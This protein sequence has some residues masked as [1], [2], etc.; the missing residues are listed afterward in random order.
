MDKRKAYP[1]IKASDF[2]KSHQDLIKSFV[3]KSDRSEIEKL[4]EQ[5]NRTLKKIVKQR[6]IT[7]TDVLKND[8]RFTNTNGG[9]FGIADEL[10]SQDGLGKIKVISNDEFE[11]VIVSRGRNQD[12]SELNAL[13]HNSKIKKGY[14]HYVNEDNPFVQT[15]IRQKYDMDKY[16]QDLSKVKR[17]QSYIEKKGFDIVPQDK[18]FGTIKES[19]FVTNFGKLQ[20]KKSQSIVQAGLKSNNPF[21]RNMRRESRPL[22]EGMGH[23]WFGRM[24]K[25]STAFGSPFRLGEFSDILKLSS[26]TIDK[27]FNNQYGIDTETTSLKASRDSIVQIS[28]KQG[29]KYKSLFMQNKNFNLKDHDFLMKT[30]IGAINTNSPIDFSKEA[31]LPSY[32]KN[33]KTLQGSFDGQVEARVLR[34]LAAQEEVK[35]YLKQAKSEK[36]NILMMNANFEINQFNEFFDGQSPVNFSDDY[37]KFRRKSNNKANSIYEKLRR[38]EISETDAFDSLVNIQKEKSTF[39]INEALSRKGKIIEIQELAKTLSAVAQQKGLI[40]KTGSF[41]VASNMEF[42]AQTLLGEKEWHEAN[43]DNSQQGRVASRLVETIQDIESGKLN[44][45]TTQNWLQARNAQVENLH[46]TSM[47]KSIKSEYAQTGDY[48]KLNPQYN[49]ERVLLSNSPIDSQALYSKAVS[50]FTQSQEYK[51]S[52]NSN[53]SIQS[54]RATDTLKKVRV[55]SML[56]GGLLLGS[57]LTNIFKFSGSDDDANTIEGLRHEGVAGSQRQINTSFGSGFRNEKF[58]GS[59]NEDPEEGMWGNL[60]A[61][62]L[63]ATAYQVFKHQALNRRLN[64]VTYLGALAPNMDNEKLLNRSNA[65][66]QDVIVAGVR[67]MEAG[68]GGFPRA[69]GI[70][71]LLSQG[72]YDTADFTVDLTTSS[73]ETYA[74]YMDKILNRK[75][76]TEGVTSL[77]FKGGRLSLNK[78]G[79]LEE[80]TGQFSLMKTVTDYNQTKKISGLA[81][82]QLYTNGIKN[83]D[84]MAEQPFLI[85]GGKGPWKKHRD[86]FNAFAHES[87]SKPLKLL[88]DPLEGLRDIIPGIDDHLPSWVKRTLGPKG[89]TRF[90]NIGLDGQELVDTVP[91]MLK[92]HAGKMA[93]FGAAVY[94]GLGTLNYGAQAIGPDGTPIGDAGLIGAAAYGVRAVHETYARISD[95]TGLTAMRDYIESK[96][97][98]SDGFQST[99]GLTLAGGLFGAAY[100]SLQDVALESTST[101]K[102]E[103]FLESNKKS[104]MDGPLGK[105]FKGEMTNVSKK[106]KTGGA[107]GFA[108]ALPFTLAGLGTDKSA[109]E[110]RQEYSGEK[111]VAIRKGRFWESGFTPFEGGEIDYYAKNWYAK[112]MDNAKDKELYG[113]DMSPIGSAVRGLVDPYWLEKKRYH[114]QPYPVTGPDGSMMGIFGPAY[115]ATLGR[116]L[117][118]V[119]TMHEGALPPELLNNTEYDADALLRKQWNSTLEFMGLRGFTLGAVKENLTGSKEIFADPNEARSAKDIDSVVRDFYD[120]QLGGGLLTTEALRRVFQSSD[121]FQKAQMGSSINLNPLQNRMP[122]WMPGAEYIK[123]FKSGD[124][125]NKV[126]DGYSRLPGAGFA[127]QYEDLEGVKPE[128][129]ADIYKYKILADVAYGSSQFREV[130]GRLQNRELTEYEQDIFEQVQIQIDEKRDSKVNVRD[131]STYDSFLGRYSAMVTDLARSNPLETLLP[132]SPA[133][134]FLGPP[135]LEDY[136]AEQQYSKE[137]RNW[138]NPIDDFLLPAVS[139]T[140]NNLGMGGINMNDQAEAENYFDKVDYTKYSNLAREAQASG[141]LKLADQY[142]I[143]AQKTYS[144]KDLYSHSANVSSA[145]PQSERKMYNYFVESDFNTKE[146]M[147]PN[148]NPR[149]RDAYQ[150]QYDK[151]LQADALRNRHG[152]DQRRV[153]R[154]IQ[155]RQQAI[156]N[157][158]NAEM[159][160]F[161]SNM[162]KSN[163]SGWDPGV[164]NS[165]VK[166]KYINNRASDY[167]YQRSPRDNPQETSA[168]SQVN[169][170]L[171]NKVS[172]DSHYSDLNKAG[173]EN[174]LVVIRPGLDN[175]AD[176]NITV[177]RRDEQNGLL[178]EWGYIV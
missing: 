51:L 133:H 93:G 75:I 80:V 20:D 154:E 143:M 172:Y 69:F 84:A 57:S 3:Q 178:R 104:K 12:K 4:Q 161:K 64:D 13:M 149:Y 130:K 144:A 142:T 165:R 36:K 33:L 125:F 39:I 100:G 10:S 155:K 150:A 141:D 54:A 113:G 114:D 128:D 25:L 42:L 86:F 15:T 106:A 2:G 68:L 171:S 151:A 91:G 17:V 158:R 43:L 174:A 166:N 89:P 112:L 109:E 98:G 132:F 159:Q 127:S 102:Y 99:I 164:N 70:G 140:M 61:T 88:A 6:R 71:D 97:P 62:G 85:T 7:E 169:I 77:H 177:D 92:K 168:A 148:V 105:I 50:E 129:Y 116:I 37:I 103:T 34:R 48:Q 90:I 107:I 111:D 153:L 28:L 146:K 67:R 152:S 9:D 11:R 175:N 22:I 167:H 41:A 35:S 101:S 176:L 78:N 65:R 83:L 47:L 119:A 138:A 45:P 136:M 137:Y 66:V 46:Y 162:P 115:E 40:P 32:G 95:I 53:K 14:I 145:L 94:F 27:T 110:L 108:L 16:T 135:D 63:G 74:K 79:V 147:L 1:S 58:H 81:K 120:L 21:M 59:G 121:S 49:K 124:P 31:L 96:A 126:K 118:P 122:S 30:G 82:S 38:K 18:T 117:K 29:D 157:R 163:W 26:E 56:L 60:A 123:D 19:D 5:T 134:K 24:R 23:G 44:K 131:E 76:S 173:I 170:D 73:G 160:D 72:M 87:L 156:N 139:M 55:G 8:I 52:I